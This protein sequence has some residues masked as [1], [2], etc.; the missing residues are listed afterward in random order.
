[1]LCLQKNNKKISEEKLKEQQAA[2]IAVGDAKH[3]IYQEKSKGV[4]LAAAESL[5]S[6]ADG[7]FET[8]EYTN[9]KSLAEQA[10]AKVEAIEKEIIERLVTIDMPDT[11]IYGE[12][13]ELKG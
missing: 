3:I 10:K 11:A 7:A 5:L 9:A 2:K 13:I 1:M 12:E 8:G 6:Q 4:D